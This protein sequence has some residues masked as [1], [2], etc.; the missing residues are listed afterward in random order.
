MFNKGDHL[1][2]VLVIL[3]L[4]NM[5]CGICSSEVIDDG[6]ELLSYSEY[7][8]FNES[9]LKKVDG[10][11]LDIVNDTGN[12]LLSTDGITLF[13]CPINGSYCEN[14][15][16][17]PD[18]TLYAVQTSIYSINFLFASCTIVLHLYFKE[19]QTVFGV[20][21]T[22][23]CFFLNVY[24]VI[25]FVYNRFQFTHTI[26]NSAVCAMFVYLR[27]IFTFLH[28]SIKFIILFHFTYL[29]YNS[30]KARSGG[31]RFDKVLMCKYIVFICS[32]TA[33]YTLVALPF[34]IAVARNGFKTEGR[35]CAVTFIDG[36][37]F[38]I[39][40]AQLAFLS[41]VE[42]ITSGI[43]IAFYFLVSKRCCGFK[44]NDIRVSVILVSTAGIN[45][46][47]F[48]ICLLLSNSTGYALLCSSV[49]TM[50]EQLILF[51]IFVTSKKVKRVI[52]TLTVF[53]S[54]NDT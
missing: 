21:I 26:D 1:L 48:L 36:T 5:I 13:V 37:S 34:D 38:L 6:I 44:T 20:L 27:G 30:Y 16:Y 10:T 42:I 8:V 25:T 35:Y 4:F 39:Y 14:D 33:I 52:T 24:Y 41:L 23:F 32:L 43:G 18:I 49:I 51:I 17:K 31:P 11:L 47:S 3:L 29:M 53:S 54:N 50:L 46:V 2:A 19:L 9:L 12:W 28:H 15:D 40:N 45:R 7:C 22:M